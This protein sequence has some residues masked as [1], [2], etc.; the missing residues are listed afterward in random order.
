ML[1]LTWAVDK[2]RGYIYPVP[3]GFGPPR[4]GPTRTRRAEVLIVYSPFIHG[5][6]YFYV[7]HYIIIVSNLC[8]GHFS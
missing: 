7:C 1:L 4:S 6:G 5:R 3:S 8:N 2:F